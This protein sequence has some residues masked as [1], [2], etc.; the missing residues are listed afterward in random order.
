MKAIVEP[1]GYSSLRYTSRIAEQTTPWLA[2]SGGEY[3][4][5]QV[6]REFNGHHGLF[7]FNDSA[8]RGSSTQISPLSSRFVVP[9]DGEIKERD[10]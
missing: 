4:P 6:N 5:E 2:F 9:I 10:R 8:L 7:L 1:T 3:L